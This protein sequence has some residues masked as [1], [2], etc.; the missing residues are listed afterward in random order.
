MLWMA[1]VAG[2]DPGHARHQLVQLRFRD[3]GRR[4]AALP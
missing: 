1:D 3:G 4:L 2:R